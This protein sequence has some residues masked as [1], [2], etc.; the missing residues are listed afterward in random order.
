[1][2]YLIGLLLLSQGLSQGLAIA[3]E[4]LSVTFLGTN[5]HKVA[6]TDEMP[7]DIDFATYNLDAKRNLE[8][9][10]GKDLPLDDEVKAQRIATARLDAMGQAPIMRSMQSISL[11]IRWDIKKLPA[12]VFGDGKYVIYGITDMPTALKIFR[13]SRKVTGG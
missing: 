13:N 5:Q 1:M 4:S 12:V 11:M 3:G 10:L 9:E 6:G 2:K 7:S 8:F